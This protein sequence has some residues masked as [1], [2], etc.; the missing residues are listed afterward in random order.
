MKRILALALVAVMMLALVAC[1]GSKT[2]T[3]PSLTYLYNEEMRIDPKNPKMAGRD[4]LVVS[5][6][7]AGPA[8]YAALAN[9]GYFD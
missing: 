5:K 7:N 9:R 6:G 4:R 8:V 3:T 1:G 2:V